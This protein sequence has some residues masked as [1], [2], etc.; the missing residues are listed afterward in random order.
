[1]PEGREV[2]WAGMLC[3]G[4]IRGCSCIFSVFKSQQVLLQSATKQPEPPQL[5]GKNDNCFWKKRDR[6]RFSFLYLRVL[7]KAT[8]VD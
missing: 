4:G 3:G 6:V 7:L 8:S 1:M 2:D 5:L